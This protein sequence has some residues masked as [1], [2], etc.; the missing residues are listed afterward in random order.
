M[1]VLKACHLG[2]EKDVIQVHR[3]A[4]LLMEPQDQEWAA[5]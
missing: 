3:L 5:L 4:L 2:L 1:P